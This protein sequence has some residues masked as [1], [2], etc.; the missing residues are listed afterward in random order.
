MCVRHD[1]ATEPFTSTNEL[2]LN[3]MAVKHRLIV[4]YLLWL[5]GISMA[6]AQ[7][8][9]LRL[10]SIFT[11][12][13]VIQQGMHA[14]VWGYASPGA[15]VTVDFA[16]FKTQAR[17]DAQGKWMI[18]MPQL[19]SGGPYDMT[20][21]AE[22]TLTLRDVM[23]GEVWV[24]SG[25]SNMEWT[26]G[27]GIGP[28]TE[29]EKASAA[30]PGIRFFVVPRQTAAAPLEDMAPGNWMMV[31][32]ESVSQLSAVAYFFARQLHLDK[33]VAVGIVSSSWGATSAQ[34]WMSAEMLATHPD[35]SERM[36]N[37]DKNPQHWTETV[38]R[39]LENDRTRDSL[40]NA[41]VNGLKAGVPMPGFDD[42]SWRAVDYPVDMDKAGK[43]GFWGI[44][45]FR[46]HF[47]LGAAA[48]GKKGT[49]RIFLRAR[50]ARIFLNGVLLANT[51]N[52]E[53]EI[54][55]AIPNGVLLDGNNVLT[56]RMYQHWGI[57]LIGTPTTIPVI[58]FGTK[59]E[60]VTLKGSWR[61]NHDLEASLPQMQG[62]YNQ[63]TVQF[64]GR[65][66]PIIPFGIRGVIWYQGESNAGQPVQYRSLFPMLI[67]DWRMRWQQGIF[68]FL[69]VQL[70][71]FK[72]KRKEPVDDLWAELREAQAL[73]LQQPAT[74][75]ASAS[76]IG[77]PLDVHP[78]NKLD[79]GKR[80]YLAAR[81]IAYGE[82]I[83]HTGPTY[84]GMERTGDT[85]RIRFTSIGKGL[86]TQ[87][88]ELLKGFSIAGQENIFQ[89]ADAIIEGDVVKVFKTGLKNPAAV[90]YA[91]ESNP[92]GNLYNREGLP[93]IPFRTDGPRLPKP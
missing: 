72:E 53:K 46:H 74:G 78:R 20:V 73:T 35:F 12:H 23:V 45:W 19:P 43:S 52:V 10:A 89:W 26:V 37:F 69:Y 88:G 62:F 86:I 75:M 14:P 70:A 81:R 17:T 34:A 2:Y 80:L 3:P 22:K 77:D 47:D 8:N 30:Y 24:A 13:M 39:N 92:D 42:K 5:A 85:I 59:G 91:W 16:G 82:D 1:Q 7:T 4:A 71:N 87:G 51:G 90:R 54:E 76:D 40:A 38:R 50:E 63:P 27:M 48:K 57:G 55:C 25:Q 49:M 79:V 6:M 28:D 93:A 29:K 83:V 15:L 68:P 60:E 41:S 9:G 31:T 61:V 11:D 21:T 64:N 66:A 44:S 56:I 18:K 36:A 65:I 33:K 67:Q 84:A 58:R 32:P